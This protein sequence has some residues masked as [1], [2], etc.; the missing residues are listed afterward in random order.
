M[1]VRFPPELVHALPEC[2]IESH[3]D[4]AEQSSLAEDVLDGL[5]RPFKELSPKHFYDERGAALFDRICELPAYYPTRTE[6]SI[7]QRFAQQIA[8]H[9]GAIELV[10]L[11][12]DFD[13][14]AYDHVVR[15]DPFH[16]WIEMRLRERRRQVVRIREVDLLVRFEAG[17]E[18]RTEISGKFTRR[19]VATDLTAAE[20]ELVNWFT[21]PDERY[22]LPLARRRGP[23]ALGLGCTA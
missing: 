12:G 10:E 14:A 11:G 5:T 3:L 23:H 18:M 2:I 16:E 22:A 7:L 21:D 19:R 4:A 17:E 1:T 13:P 6:R 20:L 15:F 9:T 8:R